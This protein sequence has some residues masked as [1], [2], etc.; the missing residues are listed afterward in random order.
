MMMNEVIISSQETQQYHSKPVIG[1][2]ARLASRPN[3][4]ALVYELL[5]SVYESWPYAYAMRI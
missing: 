3:F 4:A 5:L 1:Y 2:S